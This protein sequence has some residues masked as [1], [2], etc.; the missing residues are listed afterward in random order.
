[1]APP[2]HPRTARPEKVPDSWRPILRE[3]ATFLRELP[4]LLLEGHE[5]RHALIKGDEVLS[6][7][8][9]FED[10][11]QAGCE[12]FAWGVPFLTQPIETKYLTW[13]WPDELLELV[14]GK[15]P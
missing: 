4:R 9:T 5:G 8:D 15:S 2:P 3:F 7:W 12:R 11:Y 10:A 14:K 1:M 13:P 6:V